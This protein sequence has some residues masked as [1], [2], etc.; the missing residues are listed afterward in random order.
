MAAP[1]PPP[2]HVAKLIKKK[3]GYANYYFNELNRDRVWSQFVQRTNCGTPPGSWTLRGKMAD[4]GPFE[5]RLD[6]KEAAGLFPA[7][8][9]TVDVRVDLDQQP[10][11][12]GSGGL[13]PTLALW[14][15]LVRLGP[16]KYGEVYYLGTAPLMNRDGQ[17]DVLV[18]IHNVVESRFSFD[19]RTGQLEAIE[20]FPESDV[21]PCE[22]YFSEYREIDGCLLPH[23]IVVR[24]GD[25]VFA[26]LEVEQYELA[27][28]SNST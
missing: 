19:P 6:A 5:I 10:L 17:F 26:E 22:I 13:L 14:Q 21:D 3:S 2:P 27:A 25:A 12:L 7:S 28:D 20:M 15:R 8:R 23:R 24:H 11:P 16:E 18:G 4:G 1:E 9:D